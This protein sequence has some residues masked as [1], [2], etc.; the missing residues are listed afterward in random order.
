LKKLGNKS[1]YKLANQIGN[2]RARAETIIAHVKSKNKIYYF[3]GATLGKIVKPK[4][5][6]DFDRGPIFKS[7]GVVK[8]FG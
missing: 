8:T 3:R 5:C 1:V 7:D 4:G 6:G 2:G